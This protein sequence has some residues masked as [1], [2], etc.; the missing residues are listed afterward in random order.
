MSA[1]TFL[2]AMSLTARSNSVAGIQNSRS[3]RARLPWKVHTRRSRACRTKIGRTREKF[4]YKDP[5]CRS[6]RLAT[7]HLFWNIQYNDLI[8]WPLRSC[9]RLRENLLQFTSKEFDVPV[10][11]R[12]SLV[13]IATR[14][15]LDGSGIESRCGRDFPHPSRPALGLTQLAIKWV[16]GHSRGS[17]GRRVAPTTHSHLAPRLKKE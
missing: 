6:T 4:G 1:H 5:R 14:Y 10:V 15:G 11:G 8:P 7:S 12:D 16:P 2:S 13:G 17:S 3:N 9:N